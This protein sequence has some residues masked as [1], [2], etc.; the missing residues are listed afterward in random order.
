MG[1]DGVYESFKKQ[2]LAKSYLP[3]MDEVFEKLQSVDSEK[4]SN[5]YDT[6]TL[7]SIANREC[8]HE[9]GCCFKWG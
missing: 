5:S 7:A 3:I 1:L 4:F 2:I 6:I 8:D 9:H